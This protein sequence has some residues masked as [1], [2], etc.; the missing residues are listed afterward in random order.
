M[1]HGIVMTDE[2]IEMLKTLREEKLPNKEIA[3]ELGV[4]APTV[5][6]W[7][8]KLNLPKRIIT[9][10]SQ[11]RDRH[12]IHTKLDD[13]VYDGIWK[14]VKKRYVSPLGKFHLVVN[15][16]LREYLREHKHEL[17]G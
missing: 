8:K 3:K 15:E 11:K 16:A 7:I 9:P 10:S 5:N 6:Y 1:S 2:K 14:I 13:D 4:S 12:L 17:E